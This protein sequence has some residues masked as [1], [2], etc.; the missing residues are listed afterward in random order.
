MENLWNWN[1]I[2]DLYMGMCM[3]LLIV[4]EECYPRYDFRSILSPMLT[5][6]SW[7]I[8]VSTNALRRLVQRSKKRFM[9]SSD[10]LYPVA[11]FSKVHWGSIRKT[12]PWCV[13]GPRLSNLAKGHGELLYPAKVPR[14]KHDTRR[15]NM[16]R[17]CSECSLVCT[18]PSTLCIERSYWPGEACASDAWNLRAQVADL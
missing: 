14:N 5:N 10:C 17:I 8:G 18:D 7:C 4:A 13:P 9:L 3:C 2:G 6:W 12:S 15:I 1:S 11:S 16:R